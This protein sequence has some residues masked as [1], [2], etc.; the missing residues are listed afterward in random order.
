MWCVKGWC[1]KGLLSSR[2]AHAGSKAARFLW[3][4]E[5]SSERGRGFVLSDS[6]PPKTENTGAV[7]TSPESLMRLD[8]ASAV[9]I[10]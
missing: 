6:I 3:I 9:S 10:W 1:V 8:R 5:L 2:L 4:F 7:S